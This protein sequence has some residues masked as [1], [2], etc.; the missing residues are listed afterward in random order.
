MFIKCSYAYRNPKT[1]E[2]LDD[3][4]GSGTKL[5]FTFLSLRFSDTKRERETQFFYVDCSFIVS[6]QL[7]DTTNV[8]A[9]HRPNWSRLGELRKSTHPVLV[10]NSTNSF[11][12]SNPKILSPSLSGMT[13]FTSP[14]PFSIWGFYYDICDC[15]ILPMR[16]WTP[17]LNVCT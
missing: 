11:F 5:L 8:R 10:P 17:A 6:F 9:S 1:F 14:V 16:A 7:T 12:F 15:H 3:F 2:T 13:S 4:L